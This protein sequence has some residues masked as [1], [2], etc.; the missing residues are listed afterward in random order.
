MSITEDIYICHSGDKFRTFCNKL[1]RKVPKLHLWA[2]SCYHGDAPDGWQVEFLT[3]PLRSPPVVIR[4][5]EQDAIICEWQEVQPYVERGVPDYTYGP[6]VIRL[7]HKGEGHSSRWPA[8]CVSCGHEV[9]KL[10]YS[11]R[12]GHTGT[13][14]LYLCTSARLRYCFF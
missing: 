1:S 14:R 4:E 13:C 5:V 3:R 9:A 11:L 2:A 8:G 10:L 6:P 7:Y 12:V